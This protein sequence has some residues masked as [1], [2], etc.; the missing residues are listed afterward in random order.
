MRLKSRLA[1]VSGLLCATQL[2]SAQLGLPNGFLSFTTPSFSV[3][4][5]KD[6]QTLYSLKPAGSSFDF[7]PA[8]KMTQRQNNGQ[9]HLGDIT[10]RARK[11]GSTAW[12]NG[13]SS[14]S[15]HPVTSLA[16]SGTTLAAAN[17]APTLPSTSLLSITRRWVLQNNVLQLLFDVK[18][19]QTTAVEIGALG[20]PLEFNNIFTGRTAAQT[21]EG[22]SLFDPYP[23]Q[24]AGYVQVT[25]LLGTLRPLVVLPVGKSPLEGWRFLTESTSSAPFYQSQTFEGLYEWQFHTLAY[26]QNDW[27]KVTPWNAATSVTLQ[28]GQTRTYGVQFLLSPSIREIEST[29]RSANRPVAVGL[30]GYIL[31]TDQVGKLFLS[32]SSAVQSISVS[33]AGA[34]TWTTNSDAKSPGWVGYS[35]TA[36]TWG[37]ARLSITYSDGSLQTVHYYVTKGATQVVGDL[38]NF[39]TTS[40]WFNSTTDPFARSPSVISYDREVNAVVKDDPRAWI[41]GL[42]DEAGAGSWLAATMKQY[43]QPNAAEVAKLE[44]FMTK[45]LWGSIQN[46]DGT[47]KKSVYYYQ[48]SILPSYPYPSSI[49]WGNWWS[50]NK[51]SSFATDRGYDYA[52]VAAAYWA[53]YRVARNYPSLVKAQTWQ[54]YINQAV[55]TV[56]TLTNGRVGFANV[57]LMGETVI[58][59]LL[60]DLKREGLTTNAN[61][62]ESRMKAREAIWA[63]QRYPFGSEMAWDSTGQEGVYAWAKYFNDKTTATNALNSILAYQP[64]IPHWGY[65]G[66]ARRYWDN[67]YGGKLQRIE[68]Q[69]HHYGSGLNALPLISEFETSP[70]DHYLLRLAYGGLSGPLSNIDQAGFASASFHSFPDTLKWDGYSGDYGPNFSGHT[71]GIGTYIVNHP[72]FGWQALGGNVLSTSPTVQVQVRDPVRR[73]VYVAPL[74]ALLTLNAGAFSTVTYDPSARTVSITITA[75]PDGVTGAASAPQGRLIVQQKAILSGITLLKPTTSLAVEAGAFVVPFTSG[76][77]TVNLA[78]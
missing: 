75:V 71:M 14:T 55:L 11:V 12:L 16:V 60:D 76:S 13:D 51:A 28:A 27:S 15:R 69:I 64:L 46:S 54:W 63:N 77:A 20:I 10:F 58:R 37:R 48:P 36:H 22:C 17:L 23:G 62:I 72:D 29:L 7:I 59:L 24:D 32:Y 19:S 35:I 5:V 40:Q 25:P 66:N 18:N 4:L 67:I 41:P 42:S 44:Q 47:V 2:V 78:M 34:L 57:G 21:N 9:Y 65:N 3:Q 43:A 1:W 26:A 73:R 53:L 61:L 49:N 74:G 39:L 8:D 33:P 50:W 31:P 70:T 56:S 30:P 52:H 68:R 45:V 6:S 38:G